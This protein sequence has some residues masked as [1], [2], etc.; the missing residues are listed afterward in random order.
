[1]RIRTIQRLGLLWLLMAAACQPS[2]S[3]EL[4]T[5]AVLP[6]LAGSPPP[7][8]ATLRAS[9]APT[10]TSIFELP[11]TTAAE[12]ATALASLFPGASAAP[13]LSSADLLVTTS[14][15]S[16]LAA[17]D[18]VSIVGT[19]A[20]DGTTVM[21]TDQQGSRIAINFSPELAQMMV[22]QQVF[23]SGRVTTSDGGLLIEPSA[24]QQI[25]ALPTPDAALATPTSAAAAPPAT[26]ELTVE[27]GEALALAANLSALAAYDQ[28]RPALTEDIGSRLWI[29]ATGTPGVSWSFN[30][31][32]PESELVS[33]YTVTLEGAVVPMRD[34]PLLV[35]QTV[36]ALERDDITIDSPQV[37]DLYTASGGGDDPLSL[38]FILQ[39]GEAGAPQW[40]VY[41]AEGQVVLT[42]D[43]VSGSVLP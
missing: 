33:Q 31:Y 4:P 34:I 32:D 23:I 1:M 28:L 36:V 8:T 3:G 24:I 29:S 15:F 27:A 9:A 18:T 35:T 22:G 20:L 25:A 17:G 37:L 14:D 2:A 41:D 10:R 7:A 5:V 21:L 42:V 12:A 26:P 6:T 19:L 43:A 40:L 38:V 16:Q 13:T 39:G 30:F 11:P